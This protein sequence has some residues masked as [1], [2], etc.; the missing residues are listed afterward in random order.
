MQP[1]LLPHLGTEHISPSGIAHTPLPARLSSSSAVRPSRAEGSTSKETEE[2]MASPFE[3][4]SE[5][6]AERPEKARGGR[7]RRRQLERDSSWEK[8]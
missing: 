2:E 7:R 1:F 8:G 5:L 3:M 4:E 6:S